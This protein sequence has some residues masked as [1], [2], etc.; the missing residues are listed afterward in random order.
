MP[1]PGHS[2]TMRHEPFRNL[3]VTPVLPF[4]D[5][6]EID[7]PAYRAFLRRFLSPEAGDAGMAVI[8]NPEAGE[9]FTLDREER[10]R[11]V[12]IVLE[13]AGRSP[14]LAA[15]PRRHHRGNGADR[16]GRRRSRGGRPVRVPAD[17]SG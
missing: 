14:V 1:S 17:R 11:V 3:F 2:A 7:E 16:E 8:A 12:R 5:D 4:D 10:R 13:E 15:R 6:G 9:L